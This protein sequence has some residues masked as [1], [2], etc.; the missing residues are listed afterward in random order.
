M[1][2]LVFLTV[3]DFFCR[4]PAVSCGLFVSLLG[5]L[6]VQKT[7]TTP[8]KTVNES[9][10]VLLLPDFLLMFLQQETSDS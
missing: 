1:F 4:F 3:C 7:L 9:K 5:G 10:W 8:Q 6:F 2:L